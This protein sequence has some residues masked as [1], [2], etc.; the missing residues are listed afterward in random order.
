MKWL[1]LLLGIL[2]LGAVLRVR[3]VA[4]R[5]SVRIPPPQTSTSLPR[6][7]FEPDPNS[8]L[9]SQAEDDR[10]HTEA[11]WQHA[12]PLDDLADAKWAYLRAL[13]HGETDEARRARAVLLE[14]KRQLQ[15]QSGRRKR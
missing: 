2:A 13:K 4:R 9:L 1:V 7:E 3:R 5:D 8:G 11:A 14:L 15:T 6:A 12:D 10:G